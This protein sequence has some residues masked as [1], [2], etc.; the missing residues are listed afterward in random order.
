MQDQ[1]YLDFDS[2]DSIDTISLLPLNIRPKKL[3]P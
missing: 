2:L 3:I 1:H